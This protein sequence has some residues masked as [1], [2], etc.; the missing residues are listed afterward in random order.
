[1][2]FLCLLVGSVQNESGGILVLASGLCSEWAMGTLYLHQLF[3]PG[4]QD[5]C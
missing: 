3:L 1:M 2:G 5:W 4:G